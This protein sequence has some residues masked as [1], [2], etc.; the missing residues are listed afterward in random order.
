MTRPVYLFFLLI[1]P[2]I[3]HAQQDHKRSIE[4]HAGTQ[5]SFNESQEKF[6]G[7]SYWQINSSHRNYRA[8]IGI[9]QKVFPRFFAGSGVEISRNLVQRYFVC[10]DCQFFAENLPQSIAMTY[11]GV[12]V[13]LRYFIT[14]GK[15]GL[16]VS[17]GY[18][19]NINIDEEK[20]Q[21]GTEIPYRDFLSSATASIGLVHHL[22]QKLDFKLQ[23]NYTG[24][25]QT[26]LENSDFRQDF[27][28]LDW[29]LALNL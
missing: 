10:R 18:L 28:G 26:A 17:A 24:N 7:E 2:L 16:F 25:L 21:I 5:F 14:Q 27:I 15:T 9:W 29:A 8:G 6:S 11:L 19:A 22:T 1:F 23:L 4:F 12:P 13:N 3:T 20:D